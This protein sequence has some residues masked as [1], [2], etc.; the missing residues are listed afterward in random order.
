MMHSVQLYW[1]RR[2][3][4]FAFCIPRPLIKLL[5]TMITDLVGQFIVKVWIQSINE[6]VKTK[7]RYIWFQISIW[8]NN[9]VNILLDFNRW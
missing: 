4:P 1:M 7:F 2:R 5:I 8:L 9:N 3:N 6:Y